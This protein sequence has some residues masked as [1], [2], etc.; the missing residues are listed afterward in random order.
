MR[1][2]ASANSRRGAGRGKS[3]C[4]RRPKPGRRK[5]KFSSAPDRSSVLIL[6]GAV[7][8]P[9]SKLGPILCVPVAGRSSLERTPCKLVVPT[10]PDRRLQPKPS[11]RAERLTCR[12]VIQLRVSFE[13]LEYLF[14][15]K[16][17]TYRKPAQTHKLVCRFFGDTV[18]LFGSLF[19]PMFKIVTLLT[20]TR[21]PGLGASDI[22][23]FASLA[24]AVVS[25][26]ELRQS[27]HS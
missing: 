22:A 5:I 21:V 15:L 2:R 18:T 27:T 9:D 24:R 10:S 13:V 26:A 14:D 8:V 3:V 11:R 12:H 20:R 23:M 17:K 1:G 4:V 7:I 25:L 19:P 6:R 16:P